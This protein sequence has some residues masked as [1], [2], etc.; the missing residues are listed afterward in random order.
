MHHHVVSLAVDFLLAGPVKM[1]LFQRILLVAHADRTAWGIV[2]HDRM[3][4]INDVQRG[5]LVVKSNGR[6]IDLPRIAN[7]NGGLVVSGLAE[8]KFRVQVAPMAGALV[9]VV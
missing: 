4:V 7:V 8:S 5:R 9:S 3:T 6:Q 1:E 2:D